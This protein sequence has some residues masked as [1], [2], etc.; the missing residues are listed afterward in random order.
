[1]SD[2]ELFSL[3]GLDAASARDYMASLEAHAHQLGTELAALDSDIASW[4]QRCALAEAKN[5][6]DLADEARARVSALLE[7]QTRLKNEQ[8]EFQAGLEKLQQDFKAVAWTQRTIDPNALLKAMEAVAGPTDKVT[9]ELKRQ[10]AEEA[11]AKLKARL[12][13]DSPQKS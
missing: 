6:P 3:E 1:M 12:A 5:R 2:P 13:D 7:R 11:L 4:N 10:E 8:A 9:P